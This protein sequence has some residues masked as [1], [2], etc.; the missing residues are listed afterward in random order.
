MNVLIMTDLEGITGVNT[1]DAIFDEGELNRKACEDLMK[2][3]NAAVSGYID[4]GC[5]KVYVVDG[6]GGGKNFI[7]EMLDK[8]ATQLVYPEWENVVKNGEVQLYAE[9]GL[10]AMAGTFNAFLEHTQ[11]SKAWFDY[12]INGRSCGELIQGAGFVGAF[13]IPMVMVTG[14]IA[15]C[16]EAKE[17]LG[18]IAVA[19]VKRAVGRN[20]AISLPDD[21]ARKLIYDAAY[22]SVSLVGKIRPYKV[23]LPAEVRVVFQ[24]TDYS[25]RYLTDRTERVD[26]RTIRKWVEKI[27]SYRSLLP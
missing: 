15:V 20:T 7:P 1:I 10:H 2:D 18:D 8:R 5:E 12:S 22:R 13:G 26:S 24:R 11:N 21:E 27:D 14:D 16:E 3:T 23:H 19:P 6:H 9:V 17:F 4:A 25:D